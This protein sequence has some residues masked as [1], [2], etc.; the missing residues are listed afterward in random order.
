MSMLAVAA[1]PSIPISR[2]RRH[3]EECHWPALGNR[4]KLPQAAYRVL[5]APHLMMWV[6]SRSALSHPNGRATLLSRSVKLGPA[7]I[8]DS[9]SPARTLRQTCSNRN[10]PG[11]TAARRVLRAT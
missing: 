3:A 10:T 8:W 6:R 5:A 9:C 4:A 1:S 2:N 11:K 7:S